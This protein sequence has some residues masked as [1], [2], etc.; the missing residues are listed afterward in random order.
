MKV[1]LGSG[2][3]QASSWIVRDGYSIIVHGHKS[4]E[5]ALENFQWHVF[6]RYLVATYY[7]ELITDG[8]VC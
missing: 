4:Q 1:E 3:I 5:Y 8:T 2:L 6:D 7:H